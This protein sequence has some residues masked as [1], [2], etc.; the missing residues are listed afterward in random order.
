MEIDKMSGGERKGIL[1]PERYDTAQAGLVI[2]GTENH[3]EE[4]LFLS[5]A[6]ASVGSVFYP[7][8]QLDSLQCFNWRR[9]TVYSYVV[10]RYPSLQ[11]RIQILKTKM[12][13]SQ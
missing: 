12:I 8:C 1:A 6:E 7:C 13:Q 11:C 3:S 10:D 5:S 4:G 9:D 2:R